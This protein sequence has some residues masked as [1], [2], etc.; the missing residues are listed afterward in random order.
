LKESKKIPK[1]YT[2][3]KREELKKRMKEMYPDVDNSL[4]EEEEDNE[5]SH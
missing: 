1:T 3:R 4:W 2:Q 5:K